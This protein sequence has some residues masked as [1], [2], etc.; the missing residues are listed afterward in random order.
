VLVRVAPVLLATL[1][2][3]GLAAPSAQADDVADAQAEVTAAG[4]RLDALEQRIDRAQKEYADALSSVGQRVMH[5]VAAQTASDDAQRAARSAQATVGSSARALYIAGGQPAVVASALGATNGHDFAFRLTV[6][7]RVMT[8]VREEA[9]RARLTARD[10]AAAADR[11][12]S[13]A[14]RAVVTAER[15]RERAAELDGLLEQARAELDGLSGRAQ[16][17]KT[18]RDARQALAA[19]TAAAGAAATA[20][21][22]AQV[23]P[24]TYFALYRAAAPTCP[25][26]PWTLLAAVGQ[27]ESGHGRN[28]GPSSAGAIGPTQF[29]PRT[30]AAYAV[31]GDHDGT[32]SAWSPADA[33]FT[34]ARYLC[35][36]GGGS[37]ATVRQALFAYNRAQWYV[38]LV[39]GVQSQIETSQG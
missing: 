2:A 31:D 3:S 10:A 19:A 37:R 5:G 22:Q 8:T 29:M 38:D 11:A 25:G 35:V 24:A 32:A 20:T 23:P 36:N 28:N 30:F 12:A 9:A 7:A 17:L 13:G 34:A 1:V 16:Q 26:M 14:D 4:H 21:V 33:V 6:A 27:V 15:I 39:L 18:A